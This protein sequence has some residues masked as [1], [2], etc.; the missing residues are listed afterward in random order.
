MPTPIE[1]VANVLGGDG[2]ALDGSAPRRSVEK[3]ELRLHWEFPAE[4]WTRVADEL[5]RVAFCLFPAP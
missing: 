1:T 4:A 3:G 2:G 5:P